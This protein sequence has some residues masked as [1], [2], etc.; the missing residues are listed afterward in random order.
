MDLQKTINKINDELMSE[1]YSPPYSS[2]QQYGSPYQVP[3]PPAPSSP[4]KD[5]DDDD[6]PTL[7]HILALGS[8]AGGAYA[9]H[10]Y[11]QSKQPTVTSK[12][13]NFVTGISKSLPEIHKIINDPATQQLAHMAKEQF[14]PKVKEFMGTAQPAKPAGPIPSA[15]KP[16]GKRVSSP[17][18]RTNITRIKPK[19]DATQK[20]TP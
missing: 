9:Y 16:G 5:K 18:F 7:K 11:A 14:G 12:I 3:R 2:S 13:H 15:V 1:Y 10:K 20:P 19:V 8:M 4:K 17:R 6:N